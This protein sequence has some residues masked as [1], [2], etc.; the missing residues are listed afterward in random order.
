MDDVVHSFASVV[1]RLNVLNVRELEGNSVA[2]L[3]EVFH[4]AGRKIID[5]AHVV[6][7]LD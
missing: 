7:L 3:G 5:A 4:A 6:A 1:H 2:N